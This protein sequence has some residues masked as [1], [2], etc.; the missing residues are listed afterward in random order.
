M[1]Q[2]CLSPFLFLPPSLFFS[3]IF[4]KC[5]VLSFANSVSK[6]KLTLLTLFSFFSEP[7]RAVARDE[8]K[9]MP[10]NPP[11]QPSLLQIAWFCIISLLLVAMTRRWA[12]E[13]GTKWETTAKSVWGV[14]AGILPNG[15]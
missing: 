1:S 4:L 6:I 10:S 11:G 3:F 7:L 2:A 5:S 14:G 12:V 8:G 13:K 15:C 9:E